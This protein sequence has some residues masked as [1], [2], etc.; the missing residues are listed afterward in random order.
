[1]ES[2]AYGHYR[3]LYDFQLFHRV[4]IGKRYPVDSIVFDVVIMEH[5]VAFYIINCRGLYGWQV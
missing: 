1:V 4:E 5:A 3:F 2:L